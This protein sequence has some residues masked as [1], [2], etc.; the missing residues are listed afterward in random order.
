MVPRRPP[1]LCGAPERHGPGGRKVSLRVIVTRPA[2][3][4]GPLVEELER[5]GHDVVVCPLIALEPL[6]EE[7]VDASGY[8]WLVV[9]SANGA[10]LLAPR[11]RGRAQR[12]AAIGPATAEALAV[13]GIAVDL[14]PATATQEGL[15]AELPRPAGRVLV[16]AAEGAR[17]VLVDGLVADFL[18]LYR[19]RELRP[20]PT[21]VGDV[22]VVASASQARALARLELGVPVVSIGPQTT[23]A[24]RALGLDVAA[25]A[26]APTVSALGAA[27]DSARV[28]AR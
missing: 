2:H 17:R 26:E 25:E 18:A 5:R 4:A 3:Q 15:L 27:V 12:V 28:R 19:T 16:A 23:H 7:P 22:A 24:A 8:D 1:D 6:G 13:H 20:D 14:V 21:P 9:T 11:L 10:D